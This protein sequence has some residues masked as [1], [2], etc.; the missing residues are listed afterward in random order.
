[1]LLLV[2]FKKYY[3]KI[4]IKSFSDFLSDFV[5][6]PKGVF[7]KKIFFSTF[8]VI[9]LGFFYACGGSKSE[10][11]ILMDQYFAALEE[12]AND[13]EKAKNAEDVV[14]T[15]D[16]FT[17]KVEV[18]GDKLKAFFKDFMQNA[19]EGEIPGNLSTEI[20]ETPK[21]MEKITSKLLK[22]NQKAAKYSSDTR[23]QEARKRMSEVLSDLNT[24]ISNLIIQSIEDF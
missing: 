5:N 17:E 16:D 6:F 8:L 18:L 22:A 14:Q 3:T 21:R 4:L 24:T 12:L 15:M 23:V 11:G 20:Q 2:E 10:Y 1:L 19:K 9:L 7:M 13:I